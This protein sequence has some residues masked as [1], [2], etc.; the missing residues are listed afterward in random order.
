MT[1]V[2]VPSS[3][4][5]NEANVEPDMTQTPGSFEAT[6]DSVVL[7]VGQQLRAAREARGLTADDVAKAIKL[8][9]RQV[10]ARG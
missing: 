5:D 3:G 9:F 8:S 7:S 2:N 6:Q 4:S 1:S 10:K